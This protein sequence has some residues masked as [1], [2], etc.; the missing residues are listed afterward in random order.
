MFSLTQI[1]LIILAIVL[2]L[3]FNT[4]KG[5]AILEKNILLK[6]LLFAVN[7]FIETEEKQEPKLKKKIKNFFAKF[8]LILDMWFLNSRSNG[9]KK[10]EIYI[11]EKKD[12]E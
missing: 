1:I 9:R 12:R 10:Q 7:L 8:I 11:K 4:K 6:S 5:N 3:F 2:F